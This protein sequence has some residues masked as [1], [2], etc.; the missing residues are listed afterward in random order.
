MPSATPSSSPSI[1]LKRLDSKTHRIE[2]VRSRLLAGVDG[3]GNGP[4]Y[5]IGN[6]SP[7]G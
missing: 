7:S 6:C 2:L 1:S 5:P 4:A 3:V